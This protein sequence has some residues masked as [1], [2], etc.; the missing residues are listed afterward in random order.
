MGT[1]VLLAEDDRAVREALVRALE[2]EGH[3]V[4]AVNDGA[5]ALVAVAR[6]RPDVVIMDWMMPVLD[7]LSVCR[8]PSDLVQPASP[9]SCPRSPS[10]SGWR[11]LD[12]HRRP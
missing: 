3:E 5:A 7:G 1:L 10:R 4:E 6:D 2:L 11:H 12:L 9:T 8:R